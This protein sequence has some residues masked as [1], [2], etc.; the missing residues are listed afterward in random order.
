[1]PIALQNVDVLMTSTFVMPGLIAPILTNMQRAN[2]RQ[3]FTKPPFLLVFASFGFELVPRA[4][5]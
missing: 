3:R 5:S 2:N 4:D 1:M